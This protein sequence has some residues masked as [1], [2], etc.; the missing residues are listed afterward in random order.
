[1]SDLHAV[2]LHDTRPEPWRNGGGLTHQLLA[3]PPQAPHWQL[4]VSVAAI[5]SSGP[6]SAYPGVRRWFTV[7][8]G[9]GVGL[10]LPRGTYNL[11]PGDEPLSFDGESAAEAHLLGGPTHDLN[12]MVQRDAG[13]S[14]MW[15]AQPGDRIDGPTRWRGLYAADRVLLELD[16]RTEPVAAGTLVWTDAHDA[17]SW[18][19]HHG[20]SGHAWFMTLED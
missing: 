13:S 3:W 8:D 4:R 10:S 14:R 5:A 11:V 15:R 18:Q 20:S 2:H 16:G 9:E 1:M 17:V 7:I 12:L 6:F 19:L